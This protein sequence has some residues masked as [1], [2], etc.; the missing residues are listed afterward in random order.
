MRSHKQ[1]NTASHGCTCR[2]SVFP[3]RLPDRPPIGN[4]SFMLPHVNMIISP[5]AG[6]RRP[7]KV[8][9]GNVRHRAEQSRAERSKTNHKSWGE[10]KKTLQ[11]VIYDEAGEKSRCSL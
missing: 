5:L 3:A 11:I 8:A 6:V 7:S 10:E 2:V 9:A 1:N 4:L